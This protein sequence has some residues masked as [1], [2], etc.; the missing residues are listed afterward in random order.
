[1]PSLPQTLFGTIAIVQRLVP[2]KGIFVHTLIGAQAKIREE[3]ESELMQSWLIVRAK[4]LRAH[5]PSAGPGLRF[6]YPHQM[7][8]HSR[9]TQGYVDAFVMH[10]WLGIQKKYFNQAH[11]QAR[12]EHFC[13]NL[14]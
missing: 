9:L 5:P 4:R 14:I 11:S 3:Q 1:V 2:E 10:K 7:T 8:P 6:G 13:K 12:V